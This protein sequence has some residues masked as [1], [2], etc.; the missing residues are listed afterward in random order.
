M[1]YIQTKKCTIVKNSEEEKNF[2]AKLIEAIE[3]LNIAHIISKEV[4]E[5]IINKFADNT[6]KIWF[7]NLKVIN[8]TKYSKS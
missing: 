5:Q 8:I 3:E 1:I 4:F 7:K 2:T 6:D